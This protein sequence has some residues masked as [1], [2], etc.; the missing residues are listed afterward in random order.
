MKLLLDTG[1]LYALN[2]LS[3]A[4]HAQTIGFL[5]T[6]QEAELYLPSPVLPELCYLLHSRL[7]RPA[8]RNFLTGLINSDITLVPVE[9]FDLLRV[10]E[11]LTQYAD[12]RLDFADT[13]LIAMAERLN[14]TQILTFDHRDFAIV[15]PRHCEAFQLMP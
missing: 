9:Q 5:H 7:G 8:M 4:N 6:L 14:I 13:T 12:A 3:D 2:D 11:L 1:F 15:R 10:T